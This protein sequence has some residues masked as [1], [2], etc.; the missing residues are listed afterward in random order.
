MGAPTQLPPGMALQ[1]LAV[2]PQQTYAGQPVTITTN[3][4]NTGGTTGQYTVT[5]MINGQVE[6]SRLVSVGA[7]SA[8]PVKF[9]VTRDVPGTYTVTIGTQQASFVIIGSGGATSGSPGSGAP[10]AILIVGVLVLVTAMGLT[11]ALRRRAY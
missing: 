2:N 4:S 6:E 7:Q 5:L 9:T 11:L 1:Y 3:V 10:I 8:L